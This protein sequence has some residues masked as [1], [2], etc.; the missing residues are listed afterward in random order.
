MK[1]EI[2]GGRT[3]SDRSAVGDGQPLDS[4]RNEVAG[5]SLFYDSPAPGA[6][7]PAERA[8]RWANESR[9]FD[10]LASKLR[11][12]LAPTPPKIV[13]RYRAPRRRWCSKE[14][15]FQRM[16]SLASQRVLDLGCGEG[17]NAILMAKFGADVTG[18]DISSDCVELCRQ[19]AALDGVEQRARFVCS[20]LEVVD[21]PPA[22]FDIIWGDGVLHHLIPELGPVM[23]RLRR[24]AKPG[25]LFVFAEPVCL[26]PALR[27]LRAHVPI[28]T[29]ATPDERP[30]QRAELEIV[31]S[32]VRSLS[33][34][35]FGLFSRFGRYVVTGNF[36][37]ASPARR[38]L[39][40][41]IWRVDEA[42]L[43]VP[44][45]RTLGSSCVMYGRF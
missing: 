33:F 13:D 7:H 37:D 11:K 45:V 35:W 28:H 6:D 18:V 39:M 44:M 19:R 21:L 3:D 22:S 20:P 41:A 15:R 40:D 29:D 2:G 8:S 1:N 12:E 14:F 25:A 31:R 5:G 10:E 38:T 42:I 43:S 34:K 27:R 16:G 9:F 26:S 4:V 23:T 32:A 24:W 17:T 36:E 30:L